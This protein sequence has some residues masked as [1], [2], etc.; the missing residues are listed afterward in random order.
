MIVAVF[1]VIVVTVTI[2][3][4]TTPPTYRASAKIL[5]KFGREN[6]YIPQT[7]R[8]PVPQAVTDPS[9]EE[10]VNSEI[11]IVKARGLAEKVIR[12]IEVKTLYPNID[13][14]SLFHFVNFRSPEL[15]PLQKA[16]LQFQKMLRVE[17]I[18]KSNIIQVDFDHGRPDLAARTVTLLIDA[19]LE[20]HVTA[21]KQ[22]QD[23]DFFDKQTEA[24]GKKLQISEA[25]LQSFRNRHDISSLQEQKSVL[26]KQISDLAV[27]L[28]ITRAEINENRGKKESMEDG[29]SA[30]SPGGKFGKE[31]DLNV[32]A[33]SNIKNRIADLKLREQELTSKYPDE[34]RLVITIRKEIEQAKRL[35]AAEEKTYHDKEVKTIGHNMAALGQKESSQTRHLA[36]C[37]AELYRI[38]SL[39]NR[40]KSLERQARIDEENYQLYMRKAEEGRIS[41]A[42]DTQKIANISVIQPALVPIR[43]VKPNVKLNIF[44]AV[45]L[46]GAAGLGLAYSIDSVSH[47]FKTG[48]DVQK[49]LELPVLASLPKLKA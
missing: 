34:N 22:P 40:L 16:T 30:S 44:L 4:V 9:R 19:F 11:E 15:T 21:Y 14:P 23:H 33:I 6:V 3:S 26:L 36:R 37:Q 25:E 27:A 17:G 38:N 20:Q 13:A 5:V 45:V 18:K 8:S 46:G 7:S 28:S 32:N 49:H 47:S 39:E 2:A 29:V 41:D 31:T 1:L 12:A 43:P 10:R 48:E 42:M 24:L 35:L